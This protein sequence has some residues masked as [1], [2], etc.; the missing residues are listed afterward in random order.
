MMKSK[1]SIKKGDKVIMNS[2]YRVSEKNKGVIFTVASEPWNCCGTMVVR[3][4]NY[5]GSY[6]VD[7]LSFVK[8][9]DI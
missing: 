5:S 9:E 8:V 7:G 3:L 1:T 4:D 6:A 2:K